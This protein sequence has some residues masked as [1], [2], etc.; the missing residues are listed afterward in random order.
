MIRSELAVQ[1]P[2]RDQEL[3]DRWNIFTSHVYNVMYNIIVILCTESP[4]LVH[5]TKKRREHGVVHDT[6]CIRHSKWF[7]GI[8]LYVPSEGCDENISLVFK[9]RV[10]GS[11]V[12]CTCMPR[13]AACLY[14]YMYMYMDLHYS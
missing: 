11:V 5:V 4:N 13:V 2:C 9:D 1:I 14:M 3:L 10:Q 8:I 7:N 12:T 6:I